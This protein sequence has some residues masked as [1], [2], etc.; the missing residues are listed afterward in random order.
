MSLLHGNIFIRIGHLLF[1]WCQFFSMDARVDGSV[2]VFFRI[3]NVVLLHICGFFM[4]FQR[5]KFDV[6]ILVPRIWRDISQARCSCIAWVESAHGGFG[7]MVGNSSLQLFMRCYG[8]GIRISITNSDDQVC[9]SL[10]EAGDE[11]HLLFHS[12]IRCLS[13]CSKGRDHLHLLC[14]DGFEFRLLNRF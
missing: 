9:Y 3:L 7:G 1:P 2:G 11:M 12:F 6:S 13:G 4:A 8:G 10:L 14:H 5:R